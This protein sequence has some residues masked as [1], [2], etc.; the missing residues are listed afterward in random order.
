MLSAAAAKLLGAFFKIPLTNILGGVGMSYFSCAYSIF[1][2]VYSLT[3][4]GLTAA[5]ARMTAK[6]AASGDRTQVQS[7]RRTALILFSLAGLAG[8][9]LIALLARPFSVDITKA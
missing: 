5:V 2:P 6:A 8:S 9:F 3:V 7:I 1:M 4:T